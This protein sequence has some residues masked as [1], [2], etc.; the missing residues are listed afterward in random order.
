M[1]QDTG[2]HEAFDR[3]RKGI[4]TTFSYPVIQCVLSLALHAAQV[5]TL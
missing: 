5:R 4:E 3:L 1:K 2:W